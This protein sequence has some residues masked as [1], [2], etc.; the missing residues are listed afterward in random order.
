MLFFI[1]ISILFYRVNS[2]ECALCSGSELRATAA[3][4]HV[5]EIL[6]GNIS[7]D[8]C[9][10]V[11]NKFQLQCC[12]ER[13]LPPAKTIQYIGPYKSCDICNGKGIPLKRSMV[14]HFLY[15]GVGTCPQYYEFG[16]QG[17]I[18]N[19]LC[20]VVQYY[21]GRTCDCGTIKEEF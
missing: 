12:G 6:S 4:I 13:I 7:D 16:L 18:P 2:Q 20:S 14:M 8:F 10:R 1:F 19:H 11:R 3:C 9:T 21:S 17:K 5:S 15:L